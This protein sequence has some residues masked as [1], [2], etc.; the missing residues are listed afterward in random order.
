MADWVT[1]RVMQAREIPAFVDD[2][3]RAGCDVCAVGHDKYVLG[4]FE[5]QE[6]AAD[7][8][9]RLDEKYGDRGFLKLEIVAHLRS[10][11]RYLD[12]DSAAAH[13]TENTKRP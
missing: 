7:K 6:A 4:D 8:L 3:I 1:R 12:P 10:L 5:E 9:H 11:G 2:V 13:W